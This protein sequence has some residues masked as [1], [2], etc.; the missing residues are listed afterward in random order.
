[1]SRCSSIRLG[2]AL[3][4]VL[5][6]TATEAAGTG[7][8]ATANEAGLMRGFPPA[9]AGLVTKE[10]WLAAPYNRYAFQHSRA[11]VPSRSLNAGVPPASP[12]ESAPD[13][14][15]GGLRI[16][17][18][19]GRRVALDEFLRQTYTDAFLVLHRGRVVYERYWNGMTAS[20]PHTLFSM[21]KSFTGS[22]VGLLAERGLVAYEEVVAHYVPELEGSGFGDAS[23]RQMLDMEVA[24]AWDES[25][26]GVT[27]PNGTFVPYMKAIGFLPSGEV[28]STYQVLPTMGKVGE[29]GEKFQYVSPVTDALGWLIERV[30]GKPYAEVLRDEILVKTGLEGEAYILLDGW[31]KAL[32]TGGLNLTARDLARFGLM[33]SRTGRM[34]GHR[35]LSEEFIADTRFAGSKERYALGEK[36]SAWF[37]GGAYRNQWWVSGDEEP[38]LMAVGVFGQLLY[39][40]PA[41]EV[42]IVRLASTPDSAGPLDDPFP[43]L[44]RRIAKTLGER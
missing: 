28:S 39:A 42:V 24:V 40:N 20:A 37:P 15:I 3:L 18:V 19:D 26:E 5:H 17:G 33:V 43:D 9:A 7:I 1:M 27:D 2:L 4:A 35:I 36:D 32:A 44:F 6:P 38:F 23:L 10:N 21:T 8:P 14:R 12:L 34:N 41:A 30:A 29:H 16:K 13:G 25:P 11:L 31:G 22:L